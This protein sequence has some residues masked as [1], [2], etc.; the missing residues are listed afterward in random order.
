MTAAAVWD[1]GLVQATQAS[2]AI[3]CMAAVTALATL[4]ALG[5]TPSRYMAI[6]GVGVAFASAMA[7]PDGPW[8]QLGFTAHMLWLLAGWWWASN[9]GRGRAGRDPLAGPLRR[10]VR[11]CA[12]GL[13]GAVAP[14]AAGRRRAR[15]GPPLSPGAR[16]LIREH[17][18]RGPA[19]R[20]GG[21]GDTPAAPRRLFEAL[22]LLASAR[23]RM[24]LRDG[25]TA[26]AADAEWAIRRHGEVFGT[27]DTHAAGAGAGAGAAAI[28]PGQF[29]ARLAGARAVRRARLLGG[30]AR[31]ALLRCAGL[32]GGEE[33]A[34]TRPAGERIREHC[35][36]ELAARGGGVGSGRRGDA[37]AQMAGALALL[38]SANA[39]MRFRD[40]AEV[41]DAE[42]A[43]RRHGEV[44]AMLGTRGGA[45]AA[46]GGAAARGSWPGTLVASPAAA[47][48]CVFLAM[49]SGW[50]FPWEAAVAMVPATAAALILARGRGSPAPRGGGA[51]RE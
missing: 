41:A 24:L 48:A 15:R 18:V 13:W 32:A 42:W 6:T 40:V 44:F 35:A 11:G 29:R 9:R 30:G 12:A 28:A 39:R 2:F 7:L 3:G 38:A 33:P 36:R 16:G 14:G 1:P 26:A 8:M 49:D 5:V 25:G 10:L 43:I 45:A 50:L 34:L 22:A 47:H 23:A 51:G 31:D 19:A 27:S 46:G 37:L 21:G 20:G 4:L 17:C